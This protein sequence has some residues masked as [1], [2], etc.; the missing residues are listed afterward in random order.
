MTD[1][2]QDLLG[3]VREAADILARH[4]AVRQETDPGFDADGFFFDLRRMIEVRAVTLNL[5]LQQGP[6]GGGGADEA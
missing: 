6:M 2:Y 5:V 1:A 4:Y 3:Q